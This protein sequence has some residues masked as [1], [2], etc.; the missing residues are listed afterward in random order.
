VEEVAIITVE[1]V[2]EDQDLEVQDFTPVEIMEAVMEDS[3][4]DSEGV[5]QA[6]MVV[7]LEDITVDLGDRGYLLLVLLLLLPVMEEDLEDSEDHPRQVHPLLQAHPVVDSSEEV[8]PLP[9]L[10]Q[11]PLDKY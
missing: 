6:V 3:D 11:L 1:E 10:Q 9:L 7:I 4:L 5:T 2:S 8:L